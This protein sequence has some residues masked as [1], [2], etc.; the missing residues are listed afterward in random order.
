[1]S[2]LGR[3]MANIS[4][5]ARV[6][7]VNMTT[8]D[9]EGLKGT[10]IGNATP[11]RVAVKLNS[12]KRI[13]AVKKDN[14]LEIKSNWTNLKNSLGTT[15]RGLFKSIYAFGSRRK[16]SYKDKTIKE[17]KAMLA[18]KGISSSGMLNRKNLENALNSAS[19]SENVRNAGLNTIGVS[20]KSTSG[21]ARAARIAAYR[22]P[23]NGYRR[24]ATRRAAKAEQR[25]LFS[26]PLANLINEANRGVARLGPAAAATKVPLLRPPPGNRLARA[27]NLPPL[28]GAAEQPKYNASAVANVF[29]AAPP[30]VAAAVERKLDQ[31]ENSPATAKAVVKGIERAVNR[32]NA[33]D[34]GLAMWMQGVGKNAS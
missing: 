10:V 16:N 24:G 1:M 23:E 19:A 6:E 20:A 18:A 2:R 34:E 12:S 32:A 21:R 13:V 15:R 7:L 17:L 14:L 29:A 33:F 30:A 11:G 28:L 9:L 22:P 3:G 27:A 4:A 25:N 8:K 31:A 26:A 5:G